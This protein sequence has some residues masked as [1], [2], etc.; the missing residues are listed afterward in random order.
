MADG[1][2]RYLATLS[3]H[4]GAYAGWQSQTK[5]LGIQNMLE[6]VLSNQHKTA[7][8]ITGSGRTDTGVHA[9]GQTFHFDS[10][11]RLSSHQ[12]VQALNAKLPKDIRILKVEAVDARFHARYDVV[13]KR[14]RYRI[15]RDILTPFNY[16]LMHHEAR[17]LDEKR[18]HEAMQML[19]GTH[20]FTSL[21]ATPLREV[22]HQVRTLF[23]FRRES[24]AEGFDFILEA[25]G[26]LRYM[27][28]MVVALVLD[29]GAGKLSLDELVHI[30]QA[31]DKRLYS[32]KVP[33]QGLY[34]EEVFYED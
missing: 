4:G 17:V 14:Y 16:S 27:V 7:I 5:A 3:Y 30:L 33:A 18:M 1:V 6:S 29:V 26:F 20:D 13:R 32:G 15:S 31:Q 21:N 2:V 10:S 8:K 28:R 23:V 22:A 25:D 24:T 11:L 9:Y 19:M 12:W 34:L